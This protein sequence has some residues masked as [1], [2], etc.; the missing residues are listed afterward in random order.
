MDGIT[1]LGKLIDKLTPEQRAE[2]ERIMERYFR[3]FDRIEKRHDDEKADLITDAK[4][5]LAGAGLNQLAD[6]FVG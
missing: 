5:Q 4:E 2:F 3:R 1:Y 6:T